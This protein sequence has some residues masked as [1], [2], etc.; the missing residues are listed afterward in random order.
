MTSGHVP[1]SQSSMCLKCIFRN[2]SKNN[3]N[4]IHKYPVG[5]FY[6]TSLLILPQMLSKLYLCFGV[7]V[8]YGCNY[9]AYQITIK[10]SKSWNAQQLLL[11]SVGCHGIS[12]SRMC[13][14]GNIAP[15]HVSGYIELLTSFGLCSYLQIFIL[16][17]E[18]ALVIPGGSSA[19][20]GWGTVQQ[21]QLSRAFRPLLV[22]C[23][24]INQ[25]KSHGWAQNQGCCS[26]LQEVGRGKDN[27]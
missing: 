8:N 17:E 15:R 9:A 7:L 27:K 3:N 14:T 5:N 23:L 1:A 10:I 24:M 4:K 18:E 26:S 11:V 6:R 16:A 25:G 12:W 20:E 19:G 2:K 21:A 13:V 22:L